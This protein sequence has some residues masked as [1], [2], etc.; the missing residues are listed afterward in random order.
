MS[1]SRKN[2]LVTGG[3]DGVGKEVARGLALAGHRVIVVGRDAKKGALVE[4][5]MRETTGNAEVWFL[6][7]DLSLV[8]EVNRLANEIA[9]RWPALHYLVH[10]AGVVRGRRELTAEGV[11]SN[12]AINYLSR[13]ALTG[14]LL[15]LLEAAGRP[16]EAARIMTVSGAAQNGTIHFDDVNLTMNFTTLRAVWQFCQANDV[17]T[18]ELA[19]RLALENDTRVTITSLKLGVVKTNIRREFPRW[20]QWLVPLVFDPLIALTPREAAESALGLL[21]AEDLEGVTGALFS[22]IRKFKRVVPGARVRD[23]QEVRQLWEL[24]ERLVAKGLSLAPEGAR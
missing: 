11:E 7:A 23:P 18:V 21:L 13:F 20:M 10:S 1:G 19:R 15:P 22:K 5:E 6:Q 14:R 8:R 2:A 4:R 16:G 12:F 17:F 24:S 3:T 9:A